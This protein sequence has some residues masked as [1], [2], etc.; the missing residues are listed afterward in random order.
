MAPADE[1][2]LI[3][4]ACKAYEIAPKYVFASAVKDGMVTI[5]TAGGSRIRWKEGAEI[6]PLTQIQITG[7][8]PELERRKVIAGKPKGK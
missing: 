7:V 4:K 2:V 5:V 3:E 1:K 6:K 8:N